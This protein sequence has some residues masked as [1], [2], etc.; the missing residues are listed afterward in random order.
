MVTRQKHAKM[1]KCKRNMQ[2]NS[3]ICGEGETECTHFANSQ[4]EMCFEL[5]TCAF[6]SFNATQSCMK[7]FHQTMRSLHL[8]D[9]NDV[10]EQ[11]T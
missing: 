9:L 3:E 1:R 11:S 2:K 7:Q 8:G 5:V 6:N 4:A 10:S